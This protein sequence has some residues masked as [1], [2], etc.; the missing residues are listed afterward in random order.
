MNKSF[1]PRIRELL[2]KHPD[3]LTTTQMVEMLGISRD[4]IA[5]RSLKG[6]PD[7]YVDRWTKT[8][9][10]RGQYLAIWCVVVPPENCPYPTDRWERPRTRWQHVSNQPQFNKEKS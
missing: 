9:N 2:R 4:S 5:T 8:K 7:A 10:S 1:R 6:M 3:G